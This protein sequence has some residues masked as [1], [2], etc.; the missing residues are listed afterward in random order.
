MRRGSRRMH[1]NLRTVPVSGD[2]SGSSDLDRP[3]LRAGRER[4]RLQAEKYGELVHRHAT[5]RTELLI[6]SNVT[7]VTSITDCLSAETRG[8]ATNNSPFTGMIYSDFEP[9]S[10]NDIFGNLIDATLDL[11]LKRNL[12]NLWLHEMN[13]VL[14]EI[15]IFFFYE[16]IIFPLIDILDIIEL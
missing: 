2:S 14:N 15:N 10:S 12:I 3:G 13:F 8:F 7:N 5:S 16:K 1:A 4:L 6:S 11:F 9:R